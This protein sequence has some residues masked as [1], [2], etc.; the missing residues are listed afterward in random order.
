MTQQFAGKTALVT[1][2]GSGIGR[3][4]ALALAAEGAL[5]TVAG[6]TAETLKETVRLIEAA[7]GSARHVVADMTDEAQIER[8]VK[9]ATADTGRLDIALNNAGYDGEYQLTKDYSTDMLDHMLALNVRGVFLSMKYELQYMVAQGSGAIVNMSSGAALVGVPGF[10][11]YTATKAA[12][13]AMTKSSALE[14]APQGIR[15][16]AV[17]PGLVET[18]MIADM[19]AEDRKAFGA[20]HPLGRIARPEEIA[21]AVVWL[22]SDKSSFVTGIALPV[23]GGYSVP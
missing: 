17:C 11:G 21:D 3:A 10:S 8:A 13:V 6:R 15:I 4:S 16:N 20:A 23:D 19:P 5:V 7:G 1:G 18:P 9:A 22:A 2:G 14:V 12:E